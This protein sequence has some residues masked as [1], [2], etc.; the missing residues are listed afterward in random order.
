MASNE[1]LALQQAVGGNRIVRVFVIANT[2]FYLEGL[3][4]MLS[5]S[6]G[7]EVVGCV[8]PGTDDC[9]NKFTSTPSD[10]LLIHKQAIKE[11][12]ECFP[13][14]RQHSPT[15][16]IIVFGHDMSDNFLLKAVRAGADGYINEKMSGDHMLAAIR[17]VAEGELWVERRLLERLTF[18]IIELE[19]LF[20]HK[21]EAIRNVLTRREAQIYRCVLE[22]LSTKEIAGEINLS[23]QSIKLHLRN[24]FKK[25]DVTNKH[26]L[27][28][29]TFQKVCPVPNVLR[30]FRIVMDKPR[31]ANGESPLIED[32]LATVDSRH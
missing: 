18:R 21:I 32:T 6:S 22:G 19:E 31:L 26:Q 27:I 3:L 2:D 4:T 30:L 29:L 8:K 12:F 14:F 11:P 17:K 25:F 5:R 13:R 7:N 28:L 9:W 23:E 10:V 24:I 15:L 16:K 20:N 1:V